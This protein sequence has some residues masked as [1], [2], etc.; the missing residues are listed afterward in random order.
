MKRETVRWFC[1][2]GDKYCGWD[3]V[4]KVTAAQ[5]KN[6]IRSGNS[7]RINEL[8]FNSFTSYTKLLKIFGK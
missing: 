3:Y 7:F 4:D 6:W 2:I 8:Q 5:A 1:G